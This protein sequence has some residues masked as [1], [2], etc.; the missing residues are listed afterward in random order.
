MYNFSFDKVHSKGIGFIEN[1]IVKILDSILQ[2]TN[3][4]LNLGKNVDIY[5]DLV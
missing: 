3:F 1:E 4:R 5:L 2:N